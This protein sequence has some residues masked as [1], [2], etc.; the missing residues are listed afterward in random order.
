MNLSTLAFLSLAGHHPHHLR[1]RMFDCQESY[2]RQGVFRGGTVVGWSS[3]VGEGRRWA[4]G[5][6]DADCRCRN[7]VGQSRFSV[8]WQWRRVVAVGFV[9]RVGREP[10]LLPVCWC[11]L[12]GHASHT[13]IDRLG[14][15]SPFITTL[16]SPPVHHHHKKAVIETG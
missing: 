15:S 6:A 7:I 14:L 11:V 13:T 1:D 4:G 12:Q 9:L 5:K 2:T 10:R 16:L 8:A 3:R